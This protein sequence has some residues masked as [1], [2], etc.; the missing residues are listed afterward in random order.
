MS[1]HY[2][3]RQCGAGQVVVHSSVGPPAPQPP[4]AV[5]PLPVGSA[6]SAGIRAGTYVDA[7]LAP[8]GPGGAVVVL[9]RVLVIEQLT[10]ASGHVVYLAVPRDSERAIGTV[11]GRGQVILARVPGGT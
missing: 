9:R 3:L 1:G 10:T 7:L 8:T 11:A 4:M 6:S 2:V 5:I